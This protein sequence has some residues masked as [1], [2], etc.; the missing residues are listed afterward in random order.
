MRQART[1]LYVSDGLD[2]R[3]SLL[4]ALSSAGYDVVAAHSPHQA[5]VL[6]LHP[7]IDAAVIHASASE[8]GYSMAERL[9]FLNP[10]M[11]IVLINAGAESNGALPPCVDAA[12]YS[13]TPDE[14]VSAITA[15]LEARPW[16]CALA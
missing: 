10:E 5:V 6:S 16:T 4:Q 2:D 8:G 7:N 15:F 12:T 13:E 9:K 14:A 1:I 3:C 11:P